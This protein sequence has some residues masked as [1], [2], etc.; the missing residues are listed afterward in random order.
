M[1]Y[2]TEQGKN[3]EQTLIDVYTDSVQRS[4]PYKHM[5]LD[6]WWY[7]KGNLNGAKNWTAMT[8]IFPD[9]LQALH[10]NITMPFIGHNRWWCASHHP[11]PPSFLLL[12][13]LYA[14]THTLP[15]CGCVQG[16]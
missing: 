9:G 14:H 16:T 11:L 1:Q 12:L 3:Y 4:I 2:H 5:L 6:S 13:L 10:A 15:P 7:Y 8:S